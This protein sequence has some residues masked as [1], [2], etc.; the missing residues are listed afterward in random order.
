MEG[1]G[2]IWKMSILYEMRF[3]GGGR[4]GSGIGLNSHMLEKNESHVNYLSFA[5]LVSTV[6]FVGVLLF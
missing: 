1:G 5:T 4:V 2:V 3:K 6:P